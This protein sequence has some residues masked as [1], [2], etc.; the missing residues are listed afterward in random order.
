MQFE[1]DIS[2]SH[3]E[4]ELDNIAEQVKIRLKIEN[5]MHP[6]FSATPEQYSYWKYNN[7][8]ENEWNNKDGKQILD[9]LCK[10]V[11]EELKF[12]ASCFHTTISSIDLHY[13][14]LVINHFL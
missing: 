4:T 1:K 13:I 2:Y 3:T 14:N 9:V 5:P 12:C 8:S 11:S 6:I 7:I 10:V